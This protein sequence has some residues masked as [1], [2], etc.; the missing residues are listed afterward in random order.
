[1]EIEET[2]KYFKLTKIFVEF[3]ISLQKIDKVYIFPFLVQQFLDR[4]IK[5]QLP[6][7]IVFYIHKL[8]EKC[9]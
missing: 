2:T 6:Y 1:M 4:F 9:L 8:D 5:L 7:N 3:T